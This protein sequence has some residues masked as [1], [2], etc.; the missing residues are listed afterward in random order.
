MRPEGRRNALVG[1]ASF[2][3][4]WILVSFVVSSLVEAMPNLWWFGI[5]GAAVFYLL[6]RR[7]G[8]AIRRR[9]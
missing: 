6:A 9:P 8:G 2:A 1:A 5:P 3:L 7:F 4:A